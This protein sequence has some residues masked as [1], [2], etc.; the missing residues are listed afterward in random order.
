MS[1]ASI[2][3]RTQ[4]SVSSKRSPNERP[5]G[6]LVID[7]GEV[8]NK[9]WIYE[10]KLGEGGFGAAYLVT[11]I[12]KPG[13][14]AMKVNLKADKESD[15][16]MSI[17]VTVLR[18]LS[19]NKKYF[20]QYLESGYVKGYKYVVMEL[21]GPSLSDLQEKQSSEKFSMSTVVRIGIQLFESIEAMHACCI[22]HRDLKPGNYAIGVIN[23][24][25]VY[26]F[27]FGLVRQM[28]DHDK[29]TD[30]FR[31]RA[32]RTKPPFRG[33]YHY[34]S[35]QQHENGDSC[36]R[37]DLWSIMYSLIE[38]RTRILP[39]E[40]VKEKRK[41]GEMKKNTPLHILLQGCPVMF[42]QFIAYL[43]VLEFKHKPKYSYFV[44]GL[45]RL[46]KARGYGMNDPY[47]WEMSE[48]EEQTIEKPKVE[49]RDKRVS[50]GAVIDGSNRSANATKMSFG[51]SSSSGSDQDN[52]SKSNNSNTEQ[53]GTLN[54]KNLFFEN[55]GK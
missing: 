5:K 8:I 53:A 44:D 27:D 10:K 33:T 16:I 30:K 37:D 25:C 21:L 47:D 17:E 18:T 40:Y 9:K 49:V 2:S 38:F 14:Y 46:M 39:W 43:Q 48:T 29:K 6:P 35:P 42:A 55:F 23:R 52:N 34:C 51:D 50:H 31:L 32:E 26:I 20:P 7:K 54:S 24:Q 12:V 3:I 41:I 13:K 36:R 19:S 15:R 22:L 4:D 1:K 28:V 45:K 11:G